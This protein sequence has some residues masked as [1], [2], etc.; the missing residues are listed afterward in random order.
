MTQHGNCY[1]FMSCTYTCCLFLIKI[2]HPRYSCCTEAHLLCPNLTQG[3]CALSD[4]TASVKTKSTVN[5]NKKEREKQWQHN[6]SRA[7]TVKSKF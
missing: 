7:E 1:H 6:L 5:K 2:S 4:K 3:G